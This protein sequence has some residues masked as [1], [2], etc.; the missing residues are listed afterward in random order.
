MA[1][2]LADKMGV[3]T[4][5]YDRDLGNKLEWVG[6]STDGIFLTSAPSKENKQ[7]WIDRAE[8]EGFLARL[9]VV[10]VLRWTAYN[11]MKERSGLSP[12]QRND[13]ERSLERWYKMYSP[14]PQE[15]RLENE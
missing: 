7:Y 12:G 5:I 10:W 11:R 9:Y 8:K 1:R 13:L 15:T 14:H 3:G 4:I 6:T 2:K